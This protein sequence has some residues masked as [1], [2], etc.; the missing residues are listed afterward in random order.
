MDSNIT[1]QQLIYVVA[2]D[3]EGSFVDA[4]ES[5][6]VSQ[7]ALSMQIRK[8]ENTLGVKVFD[9]S[10]QPVVATDIGRRIIQQARMTL[11]EAGRVQELVDLSQGE[12]KGEYRI[13]AVGSVAPWALP[14]GAAHFLR[15]Y[16]EVNLILHEMS[17]VEIAEGLRHDQIDAAIVPLPFGGEGFEEWE[18]WEEE[19]V[20][21]VHR[22]HPLYRLEAVGLGDV[23]RND[24][25]LPRR[26]DP[27]RERIIRLFRDVT[28]EGEIHPSSRVIWEGSGIDPLRRMVEQ[29]LGIAILP[30]LAAAE[31][32]GGPTADMLR[33]FTEPVP[34]R[35]IG[36]VHLP[37]HSRA[38]IT[39]AFVREL[40]PAV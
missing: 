33:E 3:T 19:L 40:R 28:P 27:F 23:D 2:V 25:L 7:P 36:L 16:P 12:M 29:R 26:G 18:L 4:A 35:T 34:R 32:R 31:I 9:R 10:R 14:Q 15:R 17:E 37:A 21:Y 6:R 11:R 13:A 5:C 8:L 38:H 24:L 39:E 30:G 22:D 20:L 1:L